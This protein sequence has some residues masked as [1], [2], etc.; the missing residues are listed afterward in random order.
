MNDIEE[1]VQPALWATFVLVNL[2][3][4]GRVGLEIATDYTP[5]AFGPMAPT[6]FIELTGLA[7]WAY[8]IGAILLRQRLSRRLSRT[9]SQI[10][11][12]C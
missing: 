9:S 7:I 1:A 5:R 4:A 10:T 2:G 8:S 12:R 3:N 6:G 11:M